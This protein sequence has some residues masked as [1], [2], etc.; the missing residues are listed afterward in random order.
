ML[1]PPATVQALRQRRK[2]E[3]EAAAGLPQNTAETSASA[4]ASGQGDGQASKVTRKRKKKIFN[5]AVDLPVILGV[6]VAVM[7]FFRVCPNGRFKDPPPPKVNESEAAT[8]RAME[9]NVRERDTAL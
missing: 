2:Q 5:P 7:L 9:E 6:I 3:R 4:A 8:L 1:Q